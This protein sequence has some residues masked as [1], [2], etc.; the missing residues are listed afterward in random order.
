MSDFDSAE[1]G[2]MICVESGNVKQNK[3]SLAPGKTS[4]LR[5]ELSSTLLQ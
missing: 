4:T 2:Q 5:V 1:H 3:I